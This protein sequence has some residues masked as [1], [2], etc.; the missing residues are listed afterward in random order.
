MMEVDR[1]ARLDNQAKLRRLSLDHADEVRMFC[2]HD[3]V[4]FELLSGQ[5]S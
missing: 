4:E 2:G 3:V 5:G 1:R